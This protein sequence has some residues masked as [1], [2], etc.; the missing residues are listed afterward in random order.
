M[1]LDSISTKQVKIVPILING[2]KVA[3][4]NKLIKNQELKFNT[5]IKI[6]EANK[7][8]KYEIYSLSIP[9]SKKE[10]FRTKICTDAY[11]YWATN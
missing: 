3:T 8:L 9:N 5:P 7:L 11:L 2:K 4:T 10:M 1:K 6:K